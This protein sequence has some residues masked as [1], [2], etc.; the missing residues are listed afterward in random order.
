MTIRNGWVDRFDALK[1]SNKAK[2]EVIAALLEDMQELKSS[3]AHTKIVLLRASEDYRR[4]LNRLDD[5]RKPW[6]KKW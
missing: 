3:L 4:K 2:D 6:W 1:A 5:I